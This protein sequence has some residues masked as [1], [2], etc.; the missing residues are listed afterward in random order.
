MNSKN[1]VETDD[2]I[3]VHSVI[4]KKKKHMIPHWL[5]TINSV[6]CGQVESHGHYH[7]IRCT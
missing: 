6:S 5:P 4:V 1:H 2:V 3:T 7:W